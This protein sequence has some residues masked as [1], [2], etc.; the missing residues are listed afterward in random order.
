VIR[1]RVAGEEIQLEDSEWELWVVDGR[2]PPEAPVLDPERGWVPAGS[3]AGY[4]ALI[5]EAAARR[6]D[7]GPGLARVI[8]PARGISAT[9]TLLLVNLLVGAALMLAW[10]TGYI[11]HLLAVSAHGRLA[12]EHGAYWWWIP[13]L[14]L[15]VDLGHLFA[16]M[17][18]LLAWAGAVEFL[19]GPRWVF[20]CYLIT[21]LGGAALSF[22]G[23][24]EATLLSVG[25]SGAV[26]GLSGTVMTFVLRHYRAFSYRQR[27]KARRV[28]LPLFLALTI[29]QVF[30][31][32]Y[33]GHLGGFVTGLLLGGW[34]PPHA[35][36]LDLFRRAR[37]ETDRA[38]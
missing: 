29:P 27:W 14:F 17:V 36:V 34:L 2:I 10:S 31:A 20:A 9:E 24:P 28:Y 22:F 26:F 7:P 32:D 8:F 1:T 3:L 35:R 13:P 38:Q 16:N 21:G 11:D 4:R 15:H 33:L 30:H 37:E 19:L 18:F 25:A 23:R 12:V 6:P 5:A